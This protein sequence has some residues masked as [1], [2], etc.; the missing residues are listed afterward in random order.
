LVLTTVQKKCE[1]A[2]VDAILVADQGF[3]CTRSDFFPD[4]FHTPDGKLKIRG[5][6]AK[7]ERELWGL[8]RCLHYAIFSIVMNSF[9]ALLYALDSNNEKNG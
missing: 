7:E 3:F 6:F 4:K 8:V 9:G 2:I 1:E 5:F